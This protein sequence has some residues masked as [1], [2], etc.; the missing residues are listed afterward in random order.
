MDS[1][2]FSINKKSRSISLLFILILISC[3]DSGGDSNL[4]PAPIL[5]PDPDPDPILKPDPA[6]PPSENFNLSVWKLTLPVSQDDYFG[7]GGSSAA[8]ILPSGGILIN[9]VPLDLGFEDPDFFYTGMDGGMVFRTP[10]SGG[11]STV[12]SSYVR[13]E[14]R[15]LYH[16]IPGESTSEANWNNEGV[17][18]LTASLKV[19]D[20]WPD[21]PQTVIGQIH[22]KDSTKALL[23]LQWDGPTKA[24]RAIINKDPSS[25]DPFSLAF[26]VVGLN[27]FNYQISLEENTLNITVNGVTQSVNFGENG[28]SSVWDDHV[29]YFKAGNYV[30]ADKEAGGVFEVSFSSLLIAHGNDE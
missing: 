27:E 9:V 17:H 7:S 5:K 10:L 29:Y 12:N 21:D 18:V 26:D 19:V 22:A 14:L 23:K 28:M 30:Q 13:S 4:E 20:Y 6:V 11:A 16:W 24:V 1:H 8:E 25:G 2:F 15:E 3:Q